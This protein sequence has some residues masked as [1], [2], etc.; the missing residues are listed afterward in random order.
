MS[1]CEPSHERDAASWI[2]MTDEAF[3]LRD[4]SEDVLDMYCACKVRVCASTFM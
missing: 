2:R 3:L 4:E 1:S